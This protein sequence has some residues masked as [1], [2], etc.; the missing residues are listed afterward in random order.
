MM[1]CVSDLCCCAVCPTVEITEEPL[2]YSVAG[3]C[4]S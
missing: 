4:R 3:K 1:L 2:V